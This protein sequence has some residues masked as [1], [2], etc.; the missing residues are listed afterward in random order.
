M[1]KG[2][3]KMSEENTK[4]L[5]TSENANAEQE[6]IEVDALTAFNLKVLEF[7]KQIAETEAKVASLKNERVT[8]IYTENVKQV[9]AVN[10]ERLIKEQIEAE[11]KKKLNPSV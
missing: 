5:A 3:L 11:T 10:K 4:T 7:D 6:K 8:Y 9:I 1:I 2:S